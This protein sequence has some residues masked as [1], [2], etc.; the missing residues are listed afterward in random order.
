MRRAE[1]EIIEHSPEAKLV[2]GYVEKFP[3][4]EVRERGMPPD[5][6][7][8]LYQLRRCQSAPT[9]IRKTIKEIESAPKDVHT[10]SRFEHDVAALVATADYMVQTMGAIKRKLDYWGKRLDE[11]LPPIEGQTEA[12]MGQSPPQAGPELKIVSN[13]PHD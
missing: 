5:I 9:H 11:K 1:A 2:Q 12:I 8:L 10:R 7:D 4:R 3:W 13:L 6:T